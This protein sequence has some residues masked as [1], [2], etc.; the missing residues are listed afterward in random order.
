MG[1]GRRASARVLHRISG[2]PAIMHRGR[3]SAASE[4]LV[5]AGGARRTAA[6]AGRAP[7]IPPNRYL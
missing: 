2:R 7:S 6:A 5:R 1:G 4:Q 3:T